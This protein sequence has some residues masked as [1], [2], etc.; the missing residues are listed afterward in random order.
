MLLFCGV[1]VPSLALVALPVSTMVTVPSGPFLRGD[2]EGEPDEKPVQR[3]NV[4]T[5]SIDRTEVTVEEYAACVA[6]KAC[7]DRPAH[8]GKEAPKLPVT[9]VS[10]Q[11]AAAY[12]AWQSKRLPS[13]TEWEKAARGT[14][15][16][17]Y[18]WGSDF[19]CQRGNVGN[20]SMDGRC[21]EEGAPGKPVPVGSYVSGASP[22][23]ALDMA[24]NVWEWTA[25]FYRADAYKRNES[26][27]VRGGTADKLRVLRGGGCCSI[28][29][30]PRASDRLA[31]PLDYRDADIGFRCAK[32]GA[33]GVEVSPAPKPSRAVPA[34]NQ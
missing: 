11:D 2:N 25:D 13:E 30:L 29:G 1:F 20:F 23:G 19:S 9:Q 8:A 5:F 18:P 14:D 3:V 26:T 6:A 27:A 17:K 31:L 7:K 28:F 34:T 15:G 4:A 12:C 32:D 33:V 22:Y 10:W 21:A 16:R 24:G